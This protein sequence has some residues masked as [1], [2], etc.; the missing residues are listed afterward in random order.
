M[1]SAKCSSTRAVELKAGT[2]FLT[3]TSSLLI[4]AKNFKINYFRMTIIDNL[5]NAYR[6]SDDQSL[7]HAAVEDPNGVLHVKVTSHA[8]AYFLD[9]YN[10]DNCPEKRKVDT[11]KLSRRFAI[12]DAACLWC[13]KPSIPG[14]CHVYKYYEDYTLC[15]ECVQYGEKEDWDAKPFPWR[16]AVPKA[17]LDSNDYPLQDDVRHLQMRMTELGYLDLEDTE[18]N[19]GNYEAFTK[20]AIHRFRW[21]HDI[22]GEDMTVYDKNTERKLADVLRKRKD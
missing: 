19:V 20:N 6:I 3:V 22:Y 1:S 16:G 10:E 21:E 14:V 4:L 5:D 8:S 7:F 17:P 15:D 13:K 9:S 18:E 12:H 2:W 11:G